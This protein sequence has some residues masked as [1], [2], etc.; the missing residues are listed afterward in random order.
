[1]NE[2]LRNYVQRHTSSAMQGAVLAGSSIGHVLFILKQISATL[3][4]VN[5][6]S[7]TELKAIDGIATGTTTSGTKHEVVEHEKDFN[8]TTVTRCA[9]SSSIPAR[10][11]K[12]HVVSVPLAQVRMNSAN[13]DDRK[14]KSLPLPTM[15]E[16]TTVEKKIDML[17]DM[18]EKSLRMQAE[19]TREAMSKVNKVLEMVVAISNACKTGSSG[20]ALAIWPPEVTRTSERVIEDI[21]LAPESVNCIVDA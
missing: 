8:P 21:E 13:E 20:N 16:N 9:S 2:Q 5:A 11:D 6:R 4:D 3:E 15:P 17:L 7:K 1:M 19:H 10:Q 12:R 14:L 18:Q